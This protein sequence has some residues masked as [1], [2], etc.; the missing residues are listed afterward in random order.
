MEIRLLLLHLQIGGA[1]LVILLL[2]SVLSAAGSRRKLPKIYSYLLWLLV[3]FRL[4]CPFTIESAIGV[5]PS[6]EAGTAWVQR[7]CRQITGW[8]S[9]SSESPEGSVNGYDPGSL[10]KE[11]QTAGAGKTLNASFNEP[12]ADA[13]NEPEADPLDRNDAAGRD[14]PEA[15]LLPAPFLIIWVSGMLSVLGYNG[16]MLVQMRRRIR[17]A[18]RMAENVYLCPDFHTPFTTGLLRPRIYLPQGLGQ[19]EQAYILCHERVHIRRGDYLVKNAAFLLTAVYW[20]NPFVWVAFV[21]MERDMEMACDEKVLQLMG[22][23]IKRSYSQSLLNFAEGP[24]SAAMTPLTFGE[25]GVKQRVR[26]VLSFKEADKKG[27]KLRI[28]AGM[29][30]LAAA[31][32]VLFTSRADRNTDQE[33]M[34]VKDTVISPIQE[35]DRQ[36]GDVSMEDVSMEDVSMET[37]AP[38]QE[39]GLYDGINSRDAVGNKAQFEALYGKAGSGGSGYDFGYGKTGIA[40]DFYRTLLRRLQQGTASEADLQYTDPVGAVVKILSLGSGSGQA[41]IQEKP[42]T[43]EGMDIPWLSGLAGAGEGSTAV[44]TYTFS[45]DGSTVEIP[46]ELIEGSCGIW[47]PAG[48]GMVRMVYQCRLEEPANVNGEEEVYIQTSQYGIYRL[49]RTG[50]R[51]LYPYYISPGAVWAA[52]D[53]LL[54]FEA[55]SLYQEGNMDYVADTVCMLDVETGAFDRETLRISSKAQSR[56]INWISVYGGFIRL[57]TD[58]QQYRIPRINTGKTAL[59]GGAYWKGKAVADLDGQEQNAYGCAVRDEILAAP[60]QLFQLSNRT[61]QDTYALVDLDKDG[62]A[63]RITLSGIMAD[64]YEGYDEYVLEAGESRID[65]FAEELYNDIWAVSLDGKQ[66]LLALYEDGPSGDPVTTLFAYEN[67]ALRKAGSFPDDIR[68]CSME[69]GIIHGRARQDVL[70]TDWVRAQWRIGGSGSLEWVRQG[71]YDFMMQN[72]ITLLV[73]L[74]V[75]ERP[76][77]D[78]PVHMIEPQTVR[79]LQTEDTFRWIYMQGENGDGGWFAVDGLTVTELGV[80]Y[81]EVFENLHFA[82]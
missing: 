23:E 65:G 62:Q 14:R 8:R 44:V 50:L 30:V 13:A 60:G 48:T 18:Q 66:I 61:M 76:D 67:G 78:A 49:D 26:N 77:E 63:E 73:S 58:A 59:S 11:V 81:Y 10:P 5:M 1:V 82:G 25:N 24:D 32:I 52:A 19:E 70:Q 27:K 39:N 56:A 74:P 72:D 2:R 80:D 47:A 20:Y 51:C 43:V 7:V 57:F 28:I 53:G 21:F 34:L 16:V 31:G 15:E 68:E 46:M 75:R 4:L 37:A 64:V 71:T 54:Y 35:A 79:F 17:N 69:D 55:D 33:K 22:T 45:Q 29:I 3:F 6:Q 41:V 42:V 38:E 40:T 9:N 36:N 12:F